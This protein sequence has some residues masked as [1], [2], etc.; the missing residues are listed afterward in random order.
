MNVLQN[1]SNRTEEILQ[2]KFIRRALDETA[3]EIKKLQDN[4]MSNFKSSFWND[5]TFSVSGNT[6]TH[7]HDKRQRFVDIRTR[8]NSNGSKS[9]KKN[10][11]VHN[12]I[13]W[14]Q[15]NNL[16]R[17]LAYGYTEAVKQD[18]LSLSD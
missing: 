11:R 6:L 1:R 7:K 12:K 13:I 17:E 8:T 2:G 18:L 16:T 10:Y 3:S 15:Y 14:G 9:P 4:K 5:R